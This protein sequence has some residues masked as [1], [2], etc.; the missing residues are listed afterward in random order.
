VTTKTPAQLT[1]V[2]AMDAISS[3]FLAMMA[4]CAPWTSV[5]LIQA[6]NANTDKS[7]AMITMNPQMTFA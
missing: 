1:V 7:T 2:E 4:I 5:I 3:Q 6:V